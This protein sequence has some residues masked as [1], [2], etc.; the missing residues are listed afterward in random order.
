VNIVTDADRKA[1]AQVAVELAADLLMKPLVVTDADKQA[2]RKHLTPSGSVATEVAA[3]VGAAASGLLPLLLSVPVNSGAGL[4]IAYRRAATISTVGPGAV[5]PPA[6]PGVVVQPPPGVRLPPPATGEITGAGQP[7]TPITQQ[8]RTPITQQQLDD[9]ERIANEAAARLIAAQTALENAIRNGANPQEEAR[10]RRERDAALEE[11]R[12]VRERTNKL[13][14]EARQQGWQTWQVVGIVTAVGALALLLI[15]HERERGIRIGLARAQTGVA[16]ARQVQIEGQ[17]EALQTTTPVQNALTE[18]RTGVVNAQQ[19][20]IEGRL[21]VIQLRALRSTIHEFREWTITYDAAVAQL[22]REV[23]LTADEADVYL[24][25]IVDEFHNAIVSAYQHGVYADDAAITA[26]E[27][28]ARQQLAHIGETGVILNNPRPTPA[29]PVPITSAAEMVNQLNQ[30]FPITLGSRLAELMNLPTLSEAQALELFQLQRAR[31]MQYWNWR[32]A[33]LPA[34]QQQSWAGL[35]DAERLQFFRDLEIPLPPAPTTT[36]TSTIIPGIGPQLVEDVNAAARNLLLTDVG[37]ALRTARNA[38]LRAGLRIARF[39]EP[40]AVGLAIG[41][42][43][44]DTFEAVAIL[45]AAGEA[46]AAFTAF[47]NAA[48]ADHLITQRRIDEIMGPFAGFNPGNL[49]GGPDWTFG[50][51]HLGGRGWLARLSNQLFGPL[52]GVTS[53]NEN[54]RIIYRGVQIRRAAVILEVLATIQGIPSPNPTPPEPPP[55]PPPEPPPPPP[56]GP[57]IS[58]RIEAA[59]PTPPNLAPTTAAGTPL[60]PAHPIP[61]E[62]YEEPAGPAGPPEPT[63]ADRVR[64]AC[65]AIVARVLNYSFSY[66]Q[67]AA[68]TQLLDWAD[69]LYGGSTL[70][71][72]S[73]RYPDNDALSLLNG[74]VLVPADAQILEEAASHIPH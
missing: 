26:A 20:L 46:S 41:T 34:G 30:L 74:F 8:Q 66:S 29:I 70:S 71:L 69:T 57:T 44:N 68:R 49:V 48:I 15:R 61:P 38:A 1:A 60:T 50:S 3:G 24:A 6:G 64:A 25:P 9:A 7:G 55:P 5:A 4:G 45:T 53:E 56:P 17:A 47:A 73:D 42:T 19:A 33:H 62:A 2:G 28:A 27:T 65:N 10:L 58:E 13:V 67:D 35:Q 72:A 21:S 12:A 11:A 40:A 39:L 36:L 43:I 22:A 51:S 18:A 31:A 54:A 37:P 59:I 63:H 14:E 16:G 23:G 52:P 32:N